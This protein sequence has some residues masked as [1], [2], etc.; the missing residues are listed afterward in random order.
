VLVV[1]RAAGESIWIGEGL[2]TVVRV[3]PSVRL[4]F[5]EQGQVT[6]YGFSGGRYKSQA[7]MVIGLCRVVLMA[8]GSKEVTLGLD[9][10]MSVRI[11]RRELM[12]GE[13]TS[14]TRPDQM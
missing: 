2:L 11:V 7:S 9:A 10:P 8:V 12:P 5:V 13:D 14:N 4:E 6:K 3:R 1:T